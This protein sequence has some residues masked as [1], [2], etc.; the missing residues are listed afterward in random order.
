M[1]EQVFPR[2]PNTEAFEKI[3]EV[4]REQDN[5]NVS[6]RYTDDEVEA[7]F[8]IGEQ[9]AMMAK[10]HFE[11]IGVKVPVIDLLASCYADAFAAGM[12][13]Q[14]KKTADG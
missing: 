1:S 5:A 14:K 7:V 13:Y 12:E 10:E 6:E 9:R 11:K 3:S 2:R 4:F 8:Y